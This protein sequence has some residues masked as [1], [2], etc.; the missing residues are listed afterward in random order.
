MSHG[1]LA[2]KVAIVTGGG[3]HPDEIGTGRATSV[4]LAKEGARVLIADISTENAERTAAAIVR[5]LKLPSVPMV[6]FTY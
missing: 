1:R 4:C 5:W 6:A 3:S 2:D